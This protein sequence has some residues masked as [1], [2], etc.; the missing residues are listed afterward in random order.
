M[1]G[2]LQCGVQSLPL[3]TEE[4]IELFYDAYNPDTATHQHLV[5]FEGMTEPIV[6]KGQGLSPKPD[7]D[8]RMG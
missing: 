6:K 3:D 2:L 5:D 8:S 4:M 1:Q 7:I